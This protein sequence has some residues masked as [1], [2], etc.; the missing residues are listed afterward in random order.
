MKVGKIKV[1]S[2]IFV[3]QIQ[4][5]LAFASCSSTNLV[6]ILLPDFMPTNPAEFYGCGDGLKRAANGR[7]KG[8]IY[9]MTI[10]NN[11]DDNRC[12]DKQ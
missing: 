8:I 2:N 7:N 10:A 5:L 1:C 6:L 4:I 9:K 3:K 12:K 11:N